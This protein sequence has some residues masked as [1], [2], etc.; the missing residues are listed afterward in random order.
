M[1]NLFLAFGL[2]FFSGCG[3]FSAAL[4]QQTCLTNYNKFVCANP[5]PAQQARPTLDD[6]K[7]AEGVALHK[8]REKVA[9]IKAEGT[10]LEVRTLLENRL[11][12]APTGTKCQWTKKHGFTCASLLPAAFL[13]WLYSLL[14][15]LGAGQQPRVFARKAV[16]A[17]FLLMGLAIWEACS[18]EGLACA[19]LG[20]LF[21]S[22]QSHFSLR[23]P[24]AEG[25]RVEF[26]GQEFPY[27]KGRNPFEYPVD[28][29][30]EEEER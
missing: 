19:V 21:K 11:L 24:E 1:R 5:E 6:C 26:M 29:E 30:K 18:W 12:K 2:I 23:L 28:W 7:R 14:G 17:A 9:Y 20:W 8:G 25:E 22:L 10:C 27:K 16:C 15:R 13:A 4:Y 3:S